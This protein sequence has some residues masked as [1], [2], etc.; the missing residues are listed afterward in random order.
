MLVAVEG[1]E[2]EQMVAICLVLS[3]KVP[4][5]LLIARLMFEEVDSGCEGI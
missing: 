2:K 4:V 5:P 1:G 3:V